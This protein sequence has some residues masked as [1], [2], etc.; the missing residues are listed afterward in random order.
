MSRARAIR[1]AWILG[2]VVTGLIIAHGTANLAGGGAFDSQGARIIY[3]LVQVVAGALI[4]AGLWTSARSRR[5][6]IMLVAAGVIAISLV[7]PW[8]I[9][10]TIPVGVGLI[11][12][13]YSR[14]PA[15]A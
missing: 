2:I 13:A 15:I 7:M 14:K 12:L 11:A 6:A 5:R 9:I 1:V 8:F 3:G 4:A 10:F